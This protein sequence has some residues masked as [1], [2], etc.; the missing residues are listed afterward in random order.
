MS[1]GGGIKGE[2]RGPLDEAGVRATMFT[3][4]EKGEGK[5]GVR[6]GERRCG[7]ES[8][9]DAKKGKVHSAQGR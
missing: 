1:G 8:R 5:G 9:P 6:Y 2:E 7:A 4:E 3:K